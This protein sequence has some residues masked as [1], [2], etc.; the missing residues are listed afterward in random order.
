MIDQ[1]KNKKFLI[2]LL[3]TVFFFSSFAYKVAIRGLLKK[4]FISFFS[5]SFFNKKRR[6][7]IG[8]RT[9]WKMWWNQIDN[10]PAKES[11]QNIHFLI[12]ISGTRIS[13]YSNELINYWSN[14]CQRDCK[15]NEWATKRAKK[16]KR[17]ARV[18]WFKWNRNGIY[19]NQ[20]PYTFLM[21]L[22]WDK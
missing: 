21:A 7:R 3:L 19:I 14:K 15:K 16:E 11:K 17:N 10:I 13:K 4:E 18:D 9:K 5:S 20:K 2:L 1:S 12:Y 8:N 22:E 6:N